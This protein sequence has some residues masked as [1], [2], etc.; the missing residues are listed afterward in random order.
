MML[1]VLGKA[2]R[3]EKIT[4]CAYKEGKSQTLFAGDMILH[5]EILRSLSEIIRSNKPAQIAGNI[6]N[7]LKS[8]VVLLYTSKNN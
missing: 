5:V 2:D 1:E 4:A 8:T 7:I 3:R 6:I